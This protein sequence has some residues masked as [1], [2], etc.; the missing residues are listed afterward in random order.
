M[1]PRGAILA[2]HLLE[3]VDGATDVG[4]TRFLCRS[5]AIVDPNSSVWSDFP[6]EV[7]IYTI[8]ALDLL[9]FPG[10]YLMLRMPD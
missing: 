7:R 9:G 4:L 2:V 3:V 1:A 6:S 10:L 8:L 5:A